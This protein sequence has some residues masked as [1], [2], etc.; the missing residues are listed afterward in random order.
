[1]DGNPIRYTVGKPKSGSKE[2]ANYYR[3]VRHVMDKL[4]EIGLLEA[5]ALAQ[6]YP[7]EPLE[8]FLM[9]ST[10]SIIY[11]PSPFVNHEDLPET[12]KAINEF[13]TEIIGWDRSYSRVDPGLTTIEKLEAATLE[14]VEEDRDRVKRDRAAEARRKREEAA[15]QKEQERREQAEAE[16]RRQ[17]LP[18]AE[19][20]PVTCEFS[21]CL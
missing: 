17:V 1:M 7:A 9:Y 18:T 8:I 2:P 13:Q 10:P 14:S 11:I 16:R 19:S 21:S 15:R 4:L 6:E 5:E 20:I 12:I 3:D